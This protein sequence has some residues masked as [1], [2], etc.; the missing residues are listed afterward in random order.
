[1]Q[2]NVSFIIVAPGIAALGML[3]L[4]RNAADKRGWIW[5][6]LA[7]LVQ[8]SWGNGTRAGAWLY[9]GWMILIWIGLLGLMIDPRR[10]CKLL[11]D[12]P[13]RAAPGIEPARRDAAQSEAASKAA[14]SIRA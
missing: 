13:R 3:F 7:F 2:E 8:F 4:D 12:I 10:W 5:M 6:T 14:G 1:R 9:P 11:P